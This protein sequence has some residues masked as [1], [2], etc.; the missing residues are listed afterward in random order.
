[1]ADLKQKAQGYTNAGGECG[2]I[3][4]HYADENFT[5][6]EGANRFYVYFTDEPNQPGGNAP[7]SVST[8]NKDSGDYNW[9]SSK[10]VVY[11]VY[12]SGLN[13]YGDPHGWQNWYVKEDP[14]LFST[15]TGGQIIETTG[16]FEIS[17]DELPVTGAITQSFIIQFNITPDLTV[18]G[19]YDVTILIY[20]SDGSIKSQYT[21]ED[22]QLIAA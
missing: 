22:I 4:L 3:M 12:N 10:G 11:T 13:L 15:Y 17:L 6:R 16:A 2:G 8:V 18:G 5:F 20:S 7:W 1:M 14:T 19:V 9:D 21:Y